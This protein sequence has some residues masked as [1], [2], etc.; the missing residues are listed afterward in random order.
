MKIFPKYSYVTWFGYY[1]HPL[2]DTYSFKLVGSEG[3]IREKFCDTYCSSS[4]L[5][6]CFEQLA[7][8]YGNIRINEIGINSS[9]EFFIG[10]IKDEDEM[11]PYEQALSCSRYSGMKL[12]FE[13]IQKSKPGVNK[14]IIESLTDPIFGN[15]LRVREYSNGFE[16]TVIALEDNRIIAVTND[17]TTAKEWYEKE[18]D[19]MKWALEQ[20]EEWDSF[21]ESHHA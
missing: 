16:T 19:D 17:E 3:F 15:I 8:D 9:G 20:W 10:Y 18:K 21:K 14:Y 7:Q 12:V 5:L 1:I 11:D 13:S 6:D 2:D 4:D